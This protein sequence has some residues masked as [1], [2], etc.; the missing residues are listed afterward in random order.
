MPTDLILIGA[1]LRG[2]DSYASYALEHPTDARFVAV[3]EPDVARREHFATLHRLPSER[4]FADWRE[5]LAL[6]QLAA[7]ALVCTQDQQHVAPAVTALRAGYDVLLEKPMAPDLAGC[8]ELAQAAEHT[9]RRL[10][11]CH[12]LRY[13]PFFRALNEVLADGRIG[14]IVDVAHRENVVYWHMAHSFVRGNW[15]NTALSNPMILAKCCH[16]LDILVWNL[17]RPVQRLSS[18]GSLIEFRREQAGAEAST[19]L[20]D[21]PEIPLRCTDGCPIERQ[22]QYSAIK[23][24][25]ECR[26]WPELSERHGAPGTPPVPARWPFS[27]LSHDTSYEGRLHAL[28]TGPY[29]RCVYRSDNDVVDHQVVS[30]QLEGGATATL[31]MHGH[32]HEE[33]RTMRY[34]GTRGTLRAVWG[35]RSTIH[36]HDHRS[37]SVEAVP[38]AESSGGHGGGDW[39]LMRSF[40]G[41]LQGREQP[42]TGARESLESHLLAFAAEEARLASSVVEMGEFRSRAEETIHE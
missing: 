20:P 35:H 36:V 14:E 2:A 1:G 22:C 4:C 27:A 15:R 19:S 42:L 37:G 16:D 32:A 23:L 3:A 6:P 31:T 7:G 41:V 28:Q 34:D 40:L 8:V 10:L 39:G 11:I 5:L 38:I 30:M 33:Q 21:R 9:G 26:P 25:L 13:T 12:V 17:G 29:G 18:W 24:Y